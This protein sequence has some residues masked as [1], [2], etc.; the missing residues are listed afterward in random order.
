MLAFYE[1]LLALFQILCQT[2]NGA[3]I[4]L[5][6]GLFES[7]R[8]SQLFAA[9]PDI[10][11]GWSPLSKTCNNRRLLKYPDIDDSDA[12]RK[13][14][15]LL[16]SVIRVIVTAVFSR[17]IHNEQIKAQTRV[18][19][20]ENRS[21]MVGVFKRF[22]KIGGGA[23]AGHQETLCEL[24]KSFMVLVTATEYLDFEEEQAD[25]QQTVR[26]ALFS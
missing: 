7:V 12:L 10:G 6:S 13:F 26:P 19:L 3:T 23:P 17:G 22:A 9:D 15:D 20:A 24:V 21:C 18:F 8:E 11:I 2:K 1:S 4:V 14:Y 16:L 25:V 5:K